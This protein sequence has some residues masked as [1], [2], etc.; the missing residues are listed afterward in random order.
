MSTN[1]CGGYS[2]T[3]QCIIEYM[4]Q[5][6]TNKLI[7]PYFVEGNGSRKLQV[8]HGKSDSIYLY[9]AMENHNLCLIMAVAVLIWNNVKL[10]FCYDDCWLQ[11]LF[12]PYFVGDHKLWSQRAAYN[13]VTIFRCWSNIKVKLLVW[14]TNN[15]HVF[16]V[17]AV[18]VAGQEEQEPLLLTHCSFLVYKILIS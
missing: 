7:L 10:N 9:I 2:R 15:N 13:N 3:K 5:F 16:F 8:R 17:A 1:S 11:N 18:L 6:L 4:W 14:P 12:V